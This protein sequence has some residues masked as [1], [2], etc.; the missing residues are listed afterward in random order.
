MFDRL[1]PYHVSRLRESARLLS[2]VAIET[3]GMDSTYA[4]EKA[5]GCDWFRRVT[6]FDHAGAQGIARVGVALRV[7]LALDEIRPALV[8]IPGW[9]DVAALGALRWCVRNQ[10][11]AIMMSDSTAWDAPRVGWKEW[12]KRQIVD[13]ASSA[14][15]AGRPHAEYI[16]LLGMPEDRVFLGYDVVDNKYFAGEADKWRGR[17]EAQDQGSEMSDQTLSLG[18][19]GA[20]LQVVANGVI[21]EGVES[22][23]RA[24]ESAMFGISGDFARGETRKSPS[25][26]T[27]Y[28]L[29]SNRFVEKKNLYRL[30]EAYAEYDRCFKCSTSS[31]QEEDE[32]SRG[33]GRCGVN[34]VGRAV[35]KEA[36]QAPLPTLAGSGPA[37]RSCP[38]RTWNLCLLGDGELKGDLMALC[39]RLGLNVIEAAPWEYFEIENFKLETP[40]KSP[41]VFFPGFR[42]YDELPRFYAHASAFIHASTTEQW[43]LVVNEAMACGLPVIVSSRC[44]CATELVQ[45]GVNGF[46]FDPYDIGQLTSCMNHIAEPRLALESL[47][48]AS[49]RIIADWDLDRFA[50]GLQE[51]AA[52]ALAVGPRRAGVPQKLLLRVLA[53]G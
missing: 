36:F 5:E 9:A 31:V 29:A 39:K 3:F 19:D 48:E 27:P 34:Q 51:A 16:E 7:G 50:T 49:R 52:K 35:C 46:L 47:G 53:R 43:G 17:A 8:A 40:G 26:I 14:F 21:C 44:G 13:L 41:V 38:P 32:D 15:V 22:G 12:I 11:P 2:I 10:V 28:F 23:D 37:L 1:G 4:W 25:T 33:Q 30:I 45:E 20:G 18:R 42:Q 24:Q 6:L